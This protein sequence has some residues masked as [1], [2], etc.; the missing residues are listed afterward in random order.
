MWLGPAERAMASVMPTTEVG[1]RVLALV[2]FPSCPLPL[3]PT[4]RMV[5][6]RMAHVCAAPAASAVV[7]VGTSALD[8]P[9]RFS[10]GLFA[11]VGE[12]SL[13]EDSRALLHRNAAALRVRQWFGSC[14]RDIAVGSKNK[15]KIY[16]THFDR[17]G[18]YY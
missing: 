8:R 18:F 2:P 9:L 4:Q 15:F 1:V 11:D 14:I 5:P 3:P 16:K 7:A 17:S 6:L 12:R 13:S 10:A